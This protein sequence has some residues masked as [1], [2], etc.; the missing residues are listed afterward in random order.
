MI[1]LVVMA[2][3]KLQLSAL[4]LIGN[5]VWEKHLGIGHCLMLVHSHVI[6]I[7]RANYKWMETIRL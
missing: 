3:L 1:A 4:E 5:S 7:F 6:R 2:E